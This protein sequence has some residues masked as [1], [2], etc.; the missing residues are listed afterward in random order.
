MRWERQ[1]A[2]P[3]PSMVLSCP[4]PTLDFTLRGGCD[5]C[6][7]SGGRQEGRKVRVILSLLACPE[8]GTSPPYQGL[9]NE[10]KKMLRAVRKQARLGWV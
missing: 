5:G 4:R 9:Q 1:N 2:L 6:L 8:D 3:G 7:E 10:Q